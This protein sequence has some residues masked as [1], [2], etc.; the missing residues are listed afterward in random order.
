MQITYEGVNGQLAG[1]VL[2]KAGVFHFETTT[3]LILEDRS[4]R[5]INDRLR[6]SIKHNLSTPSK[7]AGEQGTASQIKS[8]ERT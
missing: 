4:Q 6:W 7:H 5:G 1:I 3:P 8:S 2:V